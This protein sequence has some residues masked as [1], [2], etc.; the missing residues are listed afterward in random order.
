MSIEKQCQS[1]NKVFYPRQDRIKTAK[2]CS[3]ECRIE[4]TRTGSYVDC[5]CCN[6]PHWKSRVYINKNVLN[7]CSIKCK[8]K[9]QKGINH[10][11][12][13]G[14]AINNGYRAIK[15]DGKYKMEHRLILEKHLGR[16]LTKAEIVHHINGIRIDN[17]I[18]NLTIVCSKTHEKGTLVKILQRK[19][20]ELESNENKT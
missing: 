8:L 16:K 13:K 9:C 12:W 20:R 7:F 18:E 3:V 11:G 15:I 2:Y 6:T 14:G 10:P 4:G 17:R 1:C 5:F 19:I